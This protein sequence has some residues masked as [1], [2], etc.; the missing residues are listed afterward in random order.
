MSVFATLVVERLTDMKNFSYEFYVN[1]TF[2]PTREYSN[3]DGYKPGAFMKKVYEGEVD[4]KDHNDALNKLFTMFN[5][6]HPE[7]YRNRSMSVGD[8]VMLTN[9][10]TVRYFAVASFGFTEI[11]DPALAPKVNGWVSMDTYFKHRG[12]YETLRRNGTANLFDLM[13]V[14]EESAVAREAVI[15]AGRK[16]AAEEAAAKETK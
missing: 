14:I 11:G 13:V 2:D 7:D 4:G 15:E 16:W 6:E 9:G 5:I 3:F 8:V 1:N 10:V 12:L